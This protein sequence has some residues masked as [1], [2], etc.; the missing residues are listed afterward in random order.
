MLM[1]KWKYTPKNKWSLMNYMIR[2]GALVMG[3]FLNLNDRLHPDPLFN[4]P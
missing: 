2:K 4:L 1:Q 3:R